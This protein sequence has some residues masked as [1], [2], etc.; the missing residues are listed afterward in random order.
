MLTLE[1]EFNQW[2]E[3]YEILL[4]QLKASYRF[5]NKNKIDSINKRILETQVQI[6]MCARA[7]KEKRDS[8]TN[9]VI[10]SSISTN[11]KVRKHTPVNFDSIDRDLIK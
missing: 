11:V 8:K 3:N 4:G 7:L 1:Q 10:G 2:L 5:K 6:A 9:R